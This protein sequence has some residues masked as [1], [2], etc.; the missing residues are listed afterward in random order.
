MTD[1]EPA[2]PGKASS[3]QVPRGTFLP[4]SGWPSRAAPKEVCHLSQCHL[5][6]GEFSAAV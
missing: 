6:K 2:V 3:L 4:Y 1:A 5:E